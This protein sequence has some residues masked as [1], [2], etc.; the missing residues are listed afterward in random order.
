MYHFLL[1]IWEFVAEVNELSREISAGRVK[2]EEA[3]ER[4]EKIEKI[5]PKK[6]W[7]QYM[8]AGL[9]SGTFAL[10]LGSSVLE[11]VAAFLMVFYHMCGCCLPESTTFQKLL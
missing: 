3:E 8:A 2:L 11:A 5:P 1:P 9:A 7:F 6:R 4:L 10:M